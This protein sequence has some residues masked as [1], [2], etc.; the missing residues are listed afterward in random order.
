M[1]KDLEWEPLASQ[2]EQARLCT[3]HKISKDIIHVKE[4]KYLTPATATETRGSLGILLNIQVT[5]YLRRPEPIYVR[6]A[7]VFES[8]FRQ[9]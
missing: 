8:R 3:M 2:S 4:S 6:V 1:I 9:K 5:M 7:S